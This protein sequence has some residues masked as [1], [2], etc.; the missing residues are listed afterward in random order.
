[1]IDV[2]PDSTLPS[3]LI[4]RPHALPAR[5]VHRAGINQ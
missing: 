1:V 3:L 2:I 5:P 4:R